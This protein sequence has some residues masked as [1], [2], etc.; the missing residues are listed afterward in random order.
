[1]PNPSSH[2]KPVVLMTMGAQ[3]RSGHAY[4]VMTH[5]YI[6]PLVE[7]SGCVPL[8]VPTCCGTADLEQYLDLVD[9][10][11]L[12]GAGSNIDPALYGQENLTPEKAQD[13][14][15]TVNA[16]VGIRGADQKWALEFWGQNILNRDYV[17]IVADGPLQ[18]SG[19]IRGVQAGL[20]GTKTRRCGFKTQVFGLRL[21]HQGI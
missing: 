17:Q 12:S 2:S 19:T 7:I 18:G 11:Y 10:V 13:S 14:F 4:Q 8:L 9:G 5:K 16:R 6:T 21:R 1:M 20:C 15:V 3:A